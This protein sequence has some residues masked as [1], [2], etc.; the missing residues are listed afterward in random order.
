MEKKR[1]LYNMRNSALL[2]Q[3]VSCQEYSDSLFCR[4]LRV[5]IQEPIIT[6]HIKNIFFNLE[7]K[8]CFAKQKRDLLMHKNTLYKA[9]LVGCLLIIAPV[10]IYSI[11]L[12]F[13]LFC[14]LMKVL[15]S[16]EIQCNEAGLVFFV[17]LS[18]IQSFFFYAKLLFQ[19]ILRFSLILWLSLAEMYAIF[20]CVCEK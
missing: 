1:A 5:F 10:L 11:H 19:M 17:V 6:M 8:I 7:S 15:C 14:F 18:Y 20:V 4:R 9:F 12:L 16:A 3:V 2:Y 13:P